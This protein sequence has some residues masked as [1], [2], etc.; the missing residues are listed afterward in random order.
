MGCVRFTQDDRMRSMEQ[1][2]G[3]GPDLSARLRAVER[4]ATAA[5]KVAL[6]AAERTYTQHNE[7][8]VRGPVENAVFPR[9]YYSMC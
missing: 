4:L 8:E 3:V 9:K 1:L 6:D 5:E 7:L 2:M